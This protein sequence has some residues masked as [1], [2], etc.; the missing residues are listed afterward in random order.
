MTTLRQHLGDLVNRVAYGNERIIL[1]SRGE[2]RAAIIS[3][4]EL[5][6]LQEL[7]SII[8]RE[9]A[10]KSLKTAAAMRERI[11]IW[12]ERHDVPAGDSVVDLN[13]LREER[14]AKLSDMR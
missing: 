10:E 9:E 14:D 4:I 1:V 7:D 12:Q 2:P 13:K 6:R 11:R 8:E 3:V 5:E